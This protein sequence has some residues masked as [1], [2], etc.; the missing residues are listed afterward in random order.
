MRDVQNV[1]IQAFEAVEDDDYGV[2][3]GCYP[4]RLAV[5]ISRP[6]RTFLAFTRASQAL[7]LLPSAARY[8]PYKA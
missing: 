4:F 1:T 5:L 8:P 3:F 6:P 2:V 7:E